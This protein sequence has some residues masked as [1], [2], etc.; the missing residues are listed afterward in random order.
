[1]PSLSSKPTVATARPWSRWRR[2]LLL[3]AVAGVLAAVS[4]P[5]VAAFPSLVVEDDAWFYMQIG[6]E[7]GTEGRSTFD[8]LHPTSGYHLAWA[9]IL[10]SVAAVA[11]AAG[12]GKLLYLL[13][14]IAA[15]LYIGLLVADGFGRNAT[16]RL[17]LLILVL[18]SSWLMEG[19]LLAAVILLLLREATEAGQGGA[20]DGRWPELLA[21]GAVPLVRIDGVLILLPLGLAHFISGRR[22][23][24]G[25][26]Y[27]AA[28]AGV[29]LHLA[30]M[31]A[32]FGRLTSVSSLVKA[33]RAVEFG[34]L[35][36]VERNLTGY[37]AFELA[38]AALLAALAGGA[39]CSRRASLDRRVGLLL[40]AG[41]VL[42][43]VAHVLGNPDFRHWY[44]A[45]LTFSAAYLVF[46]VTPATP[47]GAVAGRHSCPH[48]F[49][50]GQGSVPGSPAGLYCVAIDRAQLPRL[51]LLVVVLLLAARQARS[52][53]LFYADDRALRRTAR[54][55]RFF[56]ELRRAVPPEEPIYMIDGS[57]YPGFF[58]GR[59]VINGDGLVNSYAYFDPWKR[60]DLGS[61]LQRNEIRYLMTNDPL[62]GDTLI[63]YRG[64]VVRRDDVELVASTELPH[65]FQSYRLWR[66]IPDHAPARSS[67]QKGADSHDR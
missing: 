50:A 31:A 14:A 19:L 34:P 55:E 38:V 9:G 67:P 7:L 59:H 32:A 28:G 18:L 46:R 24:A 45:P 29:L 42:F 22:R 43:T 39:M 20:A 4:Y 56:D 23:A 65:R 61:Y 49:P 54:I 26:F 37:A 30:I 40:L 52:A 6:Y 11:S 58:S 25:R 35:A 16:E 5:T 66:V 48:P 3:L 60:R 8:G 64:L 53:W 27:L 15:Y 62:Q 44:L 2:R 12:G 21:A 1:M 10:A 36:I 41:P 63:D 47:A 57:G 51:A 13:L 33:Q 17:A